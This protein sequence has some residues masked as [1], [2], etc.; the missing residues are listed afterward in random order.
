MLKPMRSLLLLFASS[1]AQAEATPPLRVPELPLAQCYFGGHLRLLTVPG[2]VAGSMPIA[3]GRAILIFR[4]DKKVQIA[5]GSGDNPLRNITTKELK[6]AKAFSLAE[7]LTEVDVSGN[8]RWSLLRSGDTTFVVDS[9]ALSISKIADGID[10]GFFTENSQQI[11]LQSDDSVMTYNIASRALKT[12]AEVPGKAVVVTDRDSKN[13]F[14]IA[15]EK[16]P[17]LVKEAVW[18][19]LGSNERRLV[20]GSQISISKNE[21]ANV[22]TLK[23][24]TAAFEI[25]QPR[26]SRTK[27]S[28]VSLKIDGGYIG[29]EN[30]RSMTFQE[31]NRQVD[32]SIPLGNWEDRPVQS[33]T[34][35]FVVT[36][37]TRG[38]VTTLSMFDKT[39]VICAKRVKVVCIDCDESSGRDRSIRA[40]SDQGTKFNDKTLCETEFNPKDPQWKEFSK[41][42]SLFSE[43]GAVERWLLRFSKKGGFNA[44]EHLGILEGLLGSKEVTGAYGSL[45]SLVMANVMSQSTNLYSSLLLKYPAIRTLP[46]VATVCMTPEETKQYGKFAYSVLK[47]Q[48]LLTHFDR[49][50]SEYRY[51]T[52]FAAFLTDVEKDEF[53]D[54]IGEGA[55]RYAVQRD[56]KLQNV[57]FSKVYQFA[58]QNARKIMGL[59]SVELTDL[60]TPAASGGYTWAFALGTSRMSEKSVLTEAGFYVEEKEGF[61]YDPGG[62]F[63]QTKDYSWQHAGKKYV[64]RIAG[65][66]IPVKSDWMIKEPSI[67]YNELLSDGVLRG[68]VVAGSNLGQSKE[69]LNEYRAYYEESGFTFEDPIAVDNFKEYLKAKVIGKEA[70]DYMVKEAH[71]DG[72]D[73]NLFRMTKAVSIII[74]TKKA[75][76]YV[77]KVEIV[78]PDHNR[79]NELLSNQ[80]FGEWIRTRE[81][82]KIGQLVYINSSCWSKNKA[83]AELGA[84]RSATLVEIAT[85]TVA[86][87]FVDR[88]TNTLRILLEGLRTASDYARIRERLANSPRYSGKKEDQYIFPDEPQYEQMI[89]AGLR[90]PV[91]YSISV[92][93]QGGD[94]RATPYHFDERIHQ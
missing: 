9:Q 45:L 88:S 1:L 81:S 47:R 49:P 18:Q 85:T 38:D 26:W 43:R 22:T 2:V 64:G 20:S 21:K 70:V 62:A 75:G 32:L 74:G 3:G 29:A 78:Y 83:A 10:G 52:Q 42:L 77:E 27:T 25:H 59:P 69:T 44:S 48:L 16:F 79:G 31:G 63:E 34:D 80:E 14:V 4:P 46:P 39:N 54:L 66:A 86:Y 55:G 82:S 53:A 89:S 56:W 11:I 50:F 73:K 40:Y 71:S 68:M 33:F 28:G 84:A 58:Y 61:S 60:V 92:F 76:K 51:F 35:E 57:F 23:I 24:G 15:F 91:A 36:S 41:S 30:M 13:L 90:T 94:G 65:K 87:T 19:N 8:G 12:I 6:E 7:N 72:D 93:E 67:R 37:I 5:R 17:N